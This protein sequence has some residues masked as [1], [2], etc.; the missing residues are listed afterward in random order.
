MCC[1][2]PQG[3]AFKDIIPGGGHPGP[4]ISQATI[5]RATHNTVW[6]APRRTTF[7][8]GGTRSGRPG[9]AYGGAR[10]GAT[11]EGSSALV[12]QALPFGTPVKPDALYAAAAS[13]DVALLF[14]N[15][16]TSWPAPHVIGEALVQACMRGHMEAVKLLLLHGAPIEPQVAPASQTLPRMATS[17]TRRRVSSEST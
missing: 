11:A 15:L 13:G 2:G 7:E 4:K 14:E 12:L 6:N 10:Q 16:E 17:R 8:F 3:F 1:T 9:N 5:Q